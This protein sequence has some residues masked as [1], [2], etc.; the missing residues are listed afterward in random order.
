MSKKYSEICHLEG[1]PGIGYS[2]AKSEIF[3]RSKVPDST[4][5]DIFWK[6]HEATILTR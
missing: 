4:S 1:F 6:H 5:Q 2:Q 3:E